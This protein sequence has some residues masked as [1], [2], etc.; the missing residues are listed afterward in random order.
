MS[1]ARNRKKPKAIIF[2]CAGPTLGG[3]ERSFFSRADPLGFILF[4]RNVEH[5]AQVCALVADLRAALGRDDAPVL[6]DQEG[7]RVQRLRAPHWRDIP[8]AATFGALAAR[9][10]GAAERASRINAR[11]IAEDLRA[12][13]ITIDCVPVADLRIPDSHAIIGDRAYDGD[14]KIVARLARAAAEGLLDGGVLPVVKH[15][16]GHG[17]ATLDSHAALPT[18]DV[19][20]EEL[21]RT[22]F[23]PFRALRDLPWAMTAHVRFTAIDPRHPATTSPIVIDTVIRRDIGFKGVL[24]SD[25]L[26]MRALSGGL[27]E[28]ARDALAAGC[29]VALHCSARLAEMQEIAEAVAPLSASGA[30]RIAS[31][32][33]LRRA[34]LAAAPAVSPAALAAELDRLL[35]VAS[36][37]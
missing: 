24:V 26:S 27:G 16:P 34:R 33:R 1:S 14:P 5:P 18:V 20:Q 19:A 12:L 10:G 7:G 9:D 17:R 2:G 13:G 22:D 31:A 23:A 28:R 37:A 35:S 32:E 15:I 30:R 4:S 21:R 11:L 8:S 6:I 36:N 3:D 29:D 25:D